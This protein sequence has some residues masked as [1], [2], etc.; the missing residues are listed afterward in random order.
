MALVLS[1]EKF[2]SR[3]LSGEYLDDI[4]FDGVDDVMTI[5]KQVKDQME[6]EKGA[7]QLLAK[8]IAGVT[9]RAFSYLTKDS[10][11][12]SI[13]FIYSVSKKMEVLTK[14]SKNKTVFFTSNHF[15][16]INTL[17]CSR[18]LDV[19][20]DIFNG[21]I[22]LSIINNNKLSKYIFIIQNNTKILFSDK[23]ILDKLADSPVLFDFIQNLEFDK[24]CKHI[25]SILDDCNENVP[26]CSQLL[27]VLRLKTQRRVISSYIEPI[28]KPVSIESSE[29]FERLSS[30]VISQTILN[31]YCDKEY[32]EA[33][34]WI[35][36]VSNEDI[37]LN[38]WDYDT[39]LEYLDWCLNIDRKH[40][41]NVQNGSCNSEKLDLFYSGLKNALILKIEKILNR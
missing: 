5:V 30:E 35:K 1:E 17:L 11:K 4:C 37:I 12:A 20:I 27:K 28:E 29:E 13:S 10:S 34:E 25:Q 24:L 21:T 41:E 2:N 3:I 22:D 38:K 26:D 39:I 23:S 40:E 16:F 8:V 7:V 9:S 6:D 32:F 14:I 33:T 19:F 15:E 18:M 31:G 36:C